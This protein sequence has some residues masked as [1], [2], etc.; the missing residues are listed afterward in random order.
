MEATTAQK[1]PLEVELEL[2]H[3]QSSN[4]KD[5]NKQIAAVFLDNEGK[6]YEYT[7]A[8]RTQEAQNMAVQYAES[9]KVIG[10]KNPRVNIT[11]FYWPKPTKMKEELEVETEINPDIEKLKGMESASATSN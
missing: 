7:Q 2:V 9:P 8:M 11:H 5:G 10:Y 6:E 3:F 1:H 4:L